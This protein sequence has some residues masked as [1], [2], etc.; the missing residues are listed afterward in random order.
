MYAYGIWHFGESRKPTR[1]EVNAFIF[2]LIRWVMLVFHYPTSWWEC[3]QLGSLGLAM[4]VDQVERSMP[5][6]LCH[7]HL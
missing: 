7:R 5:K 2:L 1:K 3:G 4:T 6:S